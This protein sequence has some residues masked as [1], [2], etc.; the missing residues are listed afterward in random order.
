MIAYGRMGAGLDRLDGVLTVRSWRQL[1]CPGRIVAQDLG[2]REQLSPLFDPCAQFSLHELVRIAV[3][4]LAQLRSKS[5]GEF[6]AA[7]HCLYGPLSHAR[8]MIG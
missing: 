3:R 6:R 5:H 7:V 2:F 8:E 1:E 4:Q